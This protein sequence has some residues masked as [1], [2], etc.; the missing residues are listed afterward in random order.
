[1]KLDIQDSK[2]RLDVL[3]GT[4][5]ASINEQISAINTSI[6]DLKEMDETLDAYIKTLETTATDLQKQI[7]DANAE[8]AKVETELGE[9][10]SALEKSLLN[11]L[12]TAKEA[13]EAELL[14][15]NN[16]LAELK[17][18]DEALD[19][20]ISDLQTYVDTQL[21]STTNWANATF[22]TL[23]QYE[24][25]QTEI[26]TIKASIEQINAGVTALETRLNGKIAADIQTA[27]DALRSEL[28]T[29]YI[30][31]IENA[32]NAVTQAYT[33]AISSAKD[34]I[35]TA[36]TTAIATAIAES[37]A[38]MQAWVNIVL[39]QGYYDIATIDG[40]LSAL[41]GRL[42]ET[43]ADLQKQIEE[44]RTALEA[45]KEELTKAY[46][47]AIKEAIEENNGVINAAIAE[48]VQNLEDKLQARLTVVETN[49][50]NIQEA[51]A[52]IQGQIE[53]LLS[54]I[55]SISYIPQ[56]SDGVA[57]M[58][59]YNTT[60]QAT[61]DFEISPKEAIADLTKVWQKAISVKAV[62]T[63][64][65]AVTFIEMPVLG[66]E[67]N[68]VDGT[69]SVMVSGE[70]LSSGFYTSNQAV[71]IRLSIS[72]GN[73][74]IMSNY[75]PIMPK[76]VSADELGYNI[77]KYTSTDGNVVTPFYDDDF[78][79]NIVSNTYENGQGT[80]R[81]DGP[82]TSI[83]F[84]AFSGCNTL[85]S[86]TI[87]DSVSSLDP[88]AFSGCKNLSYFYGKYTSSDNRSL[89]VNGSLLVVAP[90]GITDY[91][92]PNNVKYISSM[93]FEGCTG[94]SSVTIPDSVEEIESGTF[95]GCKNLTGFYGKYASDDNKCLVVNGTLMCFASLGLTEYTIPNNVVTIGA[96]SFAEARVTSIIIP[97]SV[98]TID[99]SAFSDCPLLS[100][101][102][103]GNNV[104]SIGSY[105]FK[106]CH[107][108]KN[109]NISN[110]VVTIG[111]YAFY[112][113]N[114]L[115]TVVIPDSTTT[116]G[117]YAF[118]GCSSLVDLTIGAS[119]ER[120]E[121][122]AFY[123]CN[124]LCNVYCKPVTPPAISHSKTPYF[125]VTFPH[126]SELKIY[127]PRNSYSAYVQFDENSDEITAQA[128]W[129]SYNE[130]VEAYDFN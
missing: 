26:S 109:I 108:L 42:D 13:I 64:T 38:N 79:A 53:R 75:I 15:I 18:A 84:L 41:S 54:R 95:Y 30:T 128:N 115:I 37:E 113:C 80:I 61:L 129:F 91:T 14:A 2:D 35:T 78:G 83:S 101:V 40:K 57:V 85:S 99:G 34:E 96:S 48:A 126:N 106:T 114:N 98:T 22:S 87:P 51:L 100:T 28:S 63:L 74:S 50:S 49:I 43:D 86:I 27:V 102:V 17:K 39:T 76:E 1:M 123:N 89:V 124:K 29:D 93:A 72:D 4:T 44:Q 81:F 59:Y 118:E 116:I 45:S 10:I 62:E 23:A 20:K 47:N 71:S 58:K 36:Y 68:Q 77:I 110:S 117:M 25:T 69:I 21:T 67:S 6:S 90:S 8:I 3:E 103:M 66:Y 107:L 88:M 52:N 120:I 70:N 105:A 122:N 55:Q 65:R 60:S 33:A 32:V 12:N 111:G 5:I 56:Y 125:T 104:K 16:T 24:Q 130:Y 112:R 46:K 127:V 92:I 73:N 82:V 19:K 31:R 7:N 119:V 121:K 97:D 9:E 94:L 11:E